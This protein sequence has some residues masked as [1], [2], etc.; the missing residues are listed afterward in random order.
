MPLSNKQANKQNKQ[1]DA[2][3]VKELSVT[4]RRERIEG[5]CR[6]MMSEEQVVYSVRLNIEKAVEIRWLS[7][8]KSFVGDRK[9]FIFDTLLNFEPM[10][11]PQKRSDGAEFGRLRD[12]SSR[13]VENELKMI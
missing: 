2:C 12:F 13:I 9:D 1:T 7:R 5:R 11:R 4:S 8:L 6:V 10:E 3:W